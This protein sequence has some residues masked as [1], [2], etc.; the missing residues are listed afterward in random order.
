MSNIYQQALEYMTNNG[1]DTKFSNQDQKRAF[2]EIIDGLG[3]WNSIQANIDAFIT[4]PRAKKHMGIYTT[5]QDWWT[6]ECTALG[7]AKRSTIPVI[8]KEED[9]IPVSEK[10]DMI[11][12]L[13]EFALLRMYV[14][15]SFD[16][17]KELNR[18]ISTYGNL[19]HTQIKELAWPN[20]TKEE[21]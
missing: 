11:R 5:K 6:I 16:E 2:K 8:V 21:E 13:M 3:E 20:K 12:D 14:H 9:P 1:V 19:D 15:L 7:E 18:L 17:E 10:R 4:H